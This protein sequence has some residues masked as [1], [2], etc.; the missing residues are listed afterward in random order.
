MKGEAGGEGEGSKAECGVVGWG[1]EGAGC[2]W[3]GE[4]AS[5]R[6]GECRSLR[7]EFRWT[8]ADTDQNNTETSTLH[9]IKRS[10]GGSVINNQWGGGSDDTAASHQGPPDVL[11]HQPSLI[12]SQ[13]FVH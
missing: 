8:P 12:S 3:S 5:V 9:E 10:I 6:G 2:G 7:R 11:G 4:A 1:E 13:W